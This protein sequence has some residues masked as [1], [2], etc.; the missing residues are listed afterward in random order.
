MW[1]SRLSLLRATERTVDVNL[2]LRKCWLS[3]TTYVGPARREALRSPI[4]DANVLTPSPRMCITDRPYGGEAKTGTIEKIEAKT[5]GAVS[6]ACVLPLF[7]AAR[8]HTAYMRIHAGSHRLHHQ[9]REVHQCSDHWLCRQEVKQ[10]LVNPHESVE[11]PVSLLNV[12]SPGLLPARA[13]NAYTAI[14]LNL[15]F[16]SCCLSMCLLCLSLCP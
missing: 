15:S 10:R 3:A 4:Y 12:P 14:L 7:V 8:S 13:T 9:R 16:E 1:S 6:I 11:R 2:L 5:G